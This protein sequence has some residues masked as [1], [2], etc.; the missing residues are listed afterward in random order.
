MPGPK[1]DLGPKG[2]YGD[3]GSPGGKG[4]KGD[5]GDAPPFSMNWKQCTRNEGNDKRNGV[6][7]VRNESRYA[8]FDIRKCCVL[9]LPLQK[10]SYWHSTTC[11]IW[12]DSTNNAQRSEACGLRSMVLYI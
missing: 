8:V 12:R 5:T 3:K 4:K 6:L 11:G 2:D 1:G 9:E 10:I 7:L